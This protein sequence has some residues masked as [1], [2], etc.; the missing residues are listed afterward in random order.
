MKE[1]KRDAIMSQQRTYVNS[2]LFYFA[3]AWHVKSVYL[4][5]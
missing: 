3:V 5:F 1:R 4:F 2:R